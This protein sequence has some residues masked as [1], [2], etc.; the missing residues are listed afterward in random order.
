MEWVNSVAQYKELCDC[1]SAY[2]PFSTMEFGIWKSV[3]IVLL[4][5]LVRTAASVSPS[6]PGSI[7]R[8]DKSNTSPF[9]A[10]VNRGV[11]SLRFQVHQ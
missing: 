3:T 4:S 6:L 9:V 10:A 1:H 2:P 5:C 11:S 7:V 8:R